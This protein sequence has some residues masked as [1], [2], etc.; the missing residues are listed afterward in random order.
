MSFVF[1]TFMASW[2]PSRIQLKS[3]AR[4][5]STEVGAVQI[6]SASSAYRMT[7]AFLTT[8]GKLLTQMLNNKGPK[9]LSCGIPC[10]KTR[11]WDNSPFINTLWRLRARYDRRDSNFPKNT[12]WFRESNAFEISTNSRPVTFPRS[13]APR[14][15]S[16]NWT[17]AWWVLWLRLNTYWYL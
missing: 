16:L 13:M 1:F 7:R 17:I 3:R 12:L 10:V 9:M 15:Q 8:F 11:Q 2:Y 6:N 14:T 5:A 4:M